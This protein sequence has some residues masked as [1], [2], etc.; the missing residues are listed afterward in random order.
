M[1]APERYGARMVGD[2]FDV[3]PGQSAFGCVARLTRLNRFSPPDLFRLFGLRLRRADD[4]HRVLARS[5]RRRESLA[6]ALQ[7]PVPDEW[8]PECWHPFQ[9]AWPEIGTQSF[10]YCRACLRVGYHSHL[11]QL[12]WISACPWHGVRLRGECPSCGGTIAVTA[13]MGCRLLTCACGLDL[14]DERAAARLVAPMRGHA[15]AVTSYLDWVRESREANLLVGTP[16]VPFADEIARSLIRV[17]ATVVGFARF[18]ASG[19]VEAGHARNYAA[20]LSGPSISQPTDAVRM[21]ALAA[22]CPQMLELP[23]FLIDGVRAAARELAGKLPPG[24]LT[25]REQLLFL[26]TPEADL[27]G[28]KLAERPTSGT[29]RCLPPMTVGPRRFLDLSSIHPVVLRIVRSLEPASAGGCM[30]EE[31][32]VRRRVQRDLICRGYAEGMRAVLSRYAPGLHDPGR[33]RPHLT[34]GWVL[35]RTRWPY[36]ARAAFTRVDG[37][38]NAADA[39]SA[40]LRS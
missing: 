15:E 6:S 28:V 27:S 4:L 21:Q 20:R 17:P 3:V 36:R 1:I 16:E 26:G 19:N 13:G 32:D 18:K 38:S 10:R 30:A 12:P 33:D 31:I 23:E 22:D 34:A 37:A 9:G 7:V 2:R 14:M 11:H 5:A 35:L 24:S 29:V 8:N 39:L 40:A 25:E